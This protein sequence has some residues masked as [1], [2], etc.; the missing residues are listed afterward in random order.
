MK[1]HAIQTGTVQIKRRQ[2]EPARR[3]LR[4]R[5]D[6]MLDREW[7]DPL[8]ILAWAIEHPEGVIVVDTGETARA[9][10]AGYFPAWHPYYR[11]SVRFQVTADEEI[12]AQLRGA[13]LESHR[14]AA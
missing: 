9:T 8:P 10:E 1:I 12:G 2:V 14:L 13:G 11:T 4:R 5:L 6:P 7:T 3:G